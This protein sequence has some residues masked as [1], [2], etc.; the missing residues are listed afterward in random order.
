MRLLTASARLSLASG[1]VVLAEAVK[2][3]IARRE[4]GLEFNDRGDLKLYVVWALKPAK[5]PD[6]L[7]LPFSRNLQNA[8]YPCFSNRSRKFWAC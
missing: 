8:I 2:S 4:E 1:D 5:P 7:H 3:E 6:N